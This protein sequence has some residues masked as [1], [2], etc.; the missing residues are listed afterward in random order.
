MSTQTN[1]IA[2]KS[3]ALE[4]IRARLSESA[5]SF[6]NF[7]FE[8]AFTE[9]PDDFSETRLPVSVLP[10]LFVPSSSDNFD[11]EN[12]V[13]LYASLSMLDP[14]E[15]ADERIWVSLA[16][17]KYKTYT[18]ARWP[19]SSK[20]SYENHVK[21]HIMASTS[22]NRFRDQAIA[23]LWWIGRYVDRNFSDIPD[24]AFDVFFALDSDQL[25][26]FLGRP[27]LAAL[28]PV[29]R[30]IVRVTHEK[31]FGEAKIPYHRKNYRE[32]LK[33][34]DLESG[35]QLLSYTTDIAAYAQV[36]KV[37]KKYFA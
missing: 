34:L 22:R 18:H 12:C 35:R 36:E 16:L 24:Q 20:V 17:D 3:D 23:R 25:N 7:D 32:F 1:L 13:L 19:K 8:K 30:A 15:A 9:N 14:R 2:F 26:S 37:F 27:N 4:S 33:A 10:E 29:A 28:K 6:W 31:F 21:N 11:R 5:E